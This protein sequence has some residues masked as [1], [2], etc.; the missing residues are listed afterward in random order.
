MD[1]YGRDVLMMQF[2]R[3]FDRSRLIASLE[4]AQGVRW[5][6]LDE[7]ISG[8]DDVEDMPADNKD[9]FE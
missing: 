4:S 7:L 2:Q 5:K 1:I 6:A 9:A 8:A 3:M